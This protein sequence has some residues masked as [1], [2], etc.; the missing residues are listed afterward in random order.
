MNQYLI[1]FVTGLTT[2]GLSCLAVQGGLL[3]SSLERQMEQDLLN[4]PASSGKKRARVVKRARSRMALPILL[5]LGAKIMA[6]TLLGILLGALGSVL[7][8][9]TATRAVLL[10]AIG[11][12]MVGNALRMFNIHPIFRYFVIEPPK[13]I[14]RY[15][16]RTSK[17]DE[18]FTPLFLGA[19]TVLIPCGVTQAMMAVAIG[20]GDPWQ[21][22]GLMFAF[23]LGTSPVFFIV[24]FLATELGAR[25][26]SVFMRV[27]AVVVLFLGLVS[28]DSGF[29]LLGSPSVMNWSQ[30]IM[31]SYKV[32]EELPANMGDALLLNVKNDGYSPR[33][34]HAKANR[35]LKLNLVTKDTYS[36]SRCPPAARC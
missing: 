16:R 25:M 20:T 7:K 21:A 1:A 19:L 3:A 8:L 33:L 6:Y 11:L 23:T 31:D 36:C 13:F 28:V 26:E 15:I 30:S 24:S 5:F 12:F 29:T 27:V 34:L 35:P 32:S 18:L 4:R 10:I 14:T 22:A 17:N 9:N 2:G